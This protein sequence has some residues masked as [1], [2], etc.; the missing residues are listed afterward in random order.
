MAIDVQIPG[1]L[2]IVIHPAL[3]ERLHPGGRVARAGHQNDL[4]PQG[5]YLRHPVQPDDFA[6]FP[7]RDMT[8]SFGPTNACQGHEAQDQDDV[9]GA[10]EAA[11][12][13]QVLGHAAEQAIGTQRGQARQH[14]GHLDVP[15]GLE[16]SGRAL[17]Q[18]H[19]RSHPLVCAGAGRTDATG[20]LCVLTAAFCL[21]AACSFGRRDREVCQARNRLALQR[22]AQRRFIDAHKPRHL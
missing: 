3:A 2:R 4:L 18:A 14:T 21:G 13:A 8:Q 1:L 16:A 19:G 7:R 9:Q 20:R 6:E 11:R 15:S 12:K 22:L 17:R 10:V 5:A